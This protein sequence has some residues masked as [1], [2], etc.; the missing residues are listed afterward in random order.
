MAIS[1]EPLVEYRIVI[2]APKNLGKL[3]FYDRNFLLWIGP[4]LIHK[5]R[6]NMLDGRTA[7]GRPLPKYTRGYMFHK[8]KQ[9]KPAR[10]SLSMSEALVNSLKMQIQST[11]RMRIHFGGLHPTSMARANDTTMKRAE[12]LKLRQQAGKKMSPA[13]ER[14][15]ALAGQSKRQMTNQDVA[16]IVAQRWGTADFRPGAAGKPPYAYMELNRSEQDWVIREYDERVVMAKTKKLPLAITIDMLDPEVR[17]YATIQPAK[18]L[19]TTGK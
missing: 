12:A 15:I 5:F 7:D 13:Q 18:E 6:R 9:G 4:Q 8:L 2:G 11:G 16:D 10:P 1:S 3:D 14:F 19:F 17:K